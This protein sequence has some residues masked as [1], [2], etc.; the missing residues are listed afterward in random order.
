MSKQST[1]WPEGTLASLSVLPGSEEARRMTATSGRKCLDSCGNSGPLGLLEKML[2]DTSAWGS[3]MRFL[4]WK[5]KDTKQG[6][7]L[8]RL[9]P[10][11]PRTGGTES[12]LWPT[13][14]ANKIGGYSS[15]GFS[16]TLEQ[17]VRMWP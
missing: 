3:T 11:E 15:P 6:R 13:P 5:V 10:S 17:T 14:R 8:F 1:L 4:T 16:P 12:S 2:L 7:S 9:V